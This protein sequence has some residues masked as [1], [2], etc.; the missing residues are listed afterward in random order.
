MSFV[1]KVALVAL[2]LPISLVTAEQKSLESLVGTEIPVFEC[3]TLTGGALT[4]EGV[5]QLKKGA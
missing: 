3:R 2:L 5:A 1:I 4:Q